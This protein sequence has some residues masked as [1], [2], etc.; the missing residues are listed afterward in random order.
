MGLDTSILLCLRPGRANNVV[1]ESG[2][3]SRFGRFFWG[4]AQGTPNEGA[5]KLEVG[6]SGV[7]LS[8]MGMCKASLQKKKTLSKRLIHI[9]S[10]G[11]TTAARLMF[12]HC[13]V[14]RLV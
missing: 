12:H 6:Q 10:K 11:K 9:S 13:S 1:W 3:E 2:K 14:P 4:A 7:P 8:K 5:V